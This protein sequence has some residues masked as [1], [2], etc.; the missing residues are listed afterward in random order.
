[1]KRYAKKYIVQ[2]IQGEEKVNIGKD[3]KGFDKAS[4]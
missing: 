4:Y 3:M 1:L 2:F